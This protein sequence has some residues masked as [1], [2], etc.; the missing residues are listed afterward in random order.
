[1]Y[2]DLINQAIGQVYQKGM[3]TKILQGM[4]HIRNEFDEL[5]ARR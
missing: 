4:D 2:A 3:A 5:Q 1:M